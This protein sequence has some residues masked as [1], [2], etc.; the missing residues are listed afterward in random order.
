MSILSAEGQK[1]VE[2]ELVK[3]NLIDQEK[4]EEIKVAAEKEGLSLLEYNSNKSIHLPVNCG[5]RPDW[6]LRLNPMRVAGRENHFFVGAV[7]IHYHQSVSA[8]VT[9]LNKNGL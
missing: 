6:Q 9:L 5:W 4:L 7:T 8:G 3:S 2:V 1:Q